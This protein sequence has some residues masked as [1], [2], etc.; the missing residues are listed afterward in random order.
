MA[1]ALS[2]DDLRRWL[3]HFADA[4]VSQEATLNQ[5]DSATGDGEHG[6][7]LSRGVAAMRR[8]LAD[9][10]FADAQS[11]LSSVGMAIVNSVGGASGALYGTVFLRLSDA[12]AGVTEL[13]LSR[14][15]DGFA[16]AAAG[17]S[18]LGRTT[19]GD[20]TLLDA[21]HPAAQALREAS[22]AHL[23]LGTGTDRAALAA[24]TGRDATAAMAA[25]VGRGSYLGDRSLGHIDAGATSM[26]QLFRSLH[27]A[28]A[29]R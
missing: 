14:L 17:V 5:L 18:E 21:I 27:V 12:G 22:A 8:A 16:S 15:A 20:K 26:A 3:E 10:S 25:R 19:P 29:S 23:D 1:E 24:E 13:D 9:Q 6:S 4:V 28:T 7:N 2:L 11:L